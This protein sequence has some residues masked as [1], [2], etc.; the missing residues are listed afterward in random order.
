MSNTGFDPFFVNTQLR[1]DLESNSEDMQVIENLDSTMGAGKKKK[2]KEKNKRDR[3]VGGAD[4]EDEDD[5]DDNVYTIL[6]RSQIASSLKHHCRISSDKSSAVDGDGGKHVESKSDIVAAETAEEKD[7]FTLRQEKDNVQEKLNKTKRKLEELVWDKR[8]RGYVEV[9]KVCVQCFHKA[10]MNNLGKRDESTEL[11]EVRA[12]MQRCTTTEALDG[13]RLG[14][15]DNFIERIEKTVHIGEVPEN[16]LELI[17]IENSVDNMVEGFVRDVTYELAVPV[18]VKQEKVEKAPGDDDDDDL[19]IVG[20][21]EATIRPVDI[22]QVKREPPS[23]PPALPE[24]RQENK[25]VSGPAEKEVFEAEDS[26]RGSPHK[27]QKVVSKATEDAVAEDKS[28]KSSSQSTPQKQQ[29]QVKATK[30]GSQ[31]IDIENT[32]SPEKG[33][34]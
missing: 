13:F 14:V 19:E 20:Y 25:E 11:T 34:G 1:Q 28:G 15:C 21:T 12:D 23:P 18:V 10:I 22:Q 33:E 3:E 5:D 31:E 17:K 26:T 29:K 32:Q 30:M 27:K 6:G 7:W 9:V 24:N 2:K 4:E 8:A 16:K